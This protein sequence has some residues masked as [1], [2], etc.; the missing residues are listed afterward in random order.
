[1]EEPTLG[2]IG[3]GNAGYH[4][5]ACLAKKGHR[6]LVRDVDPAQGILFVA[7]YPTS[8]VATQGADSFQHCTAVVTMLS[9]SILLRDVLLGEHG[10]APHLTPGMPH[11]IQSPKMVPYVE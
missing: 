9:D 5:A 6:L 3:L 10:I 1:M 11:L 8:R 2:W 7:E 4:L